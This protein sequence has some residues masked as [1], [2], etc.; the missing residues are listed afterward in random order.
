MQLKLVLKKL[1]L[2]ERRRKNREMRIKI[3]T[4]LIAIFLIFMILFSSCFNIIY[5]TEDIIAVSSEELTEENEEIETQE[6][7]LDISYVLS[8]DYSYIIVEISLETKVITKIELALEE[9]VIDLTEDSY[10]FDDD[11]GN[12]TISDDGS[13]A[14]KDYYQNTNDCIKITYEDEATEI[15]NIAVSGLSSNKVYT[16]VIEE[17]TNEDTEV[18]QV[19]EETEEDNVTTSSNDDSGVASVSEDDV[20]SIAV[21]N[22]TDYETITETTLLEQNDN[23]KLV[24]DMQNDPVI[25][26]VTGTDYQSYSNSYTNDNEYNGCIIYLTDSSWDATLDL[27]FDV[28]FTKVGTYNGEDIDMKIHISEITIVNENEAALVDW[29]VGTT[30]FMYWTNY[31]TTSNQKSDNEWWYALVE[32]FRTRIVFYYTDEA[33]ENIYNK[34]E[35]D[36]LFVS[37]YSLDGNEG[38]KSTNYTTQYLFDPT[39][40]KLASSYSVVHCG[41]TYTNFFYGSNTADSDG[42]RSY[43]A[44]AFLGCAYEFKDKSEL[45]F[46][47]GFYDSVGISSRTDSTRLPFLI[48]YTDS[49]SAR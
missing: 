18:A 42:N 14:T 37:L 26:N 36:D 2:K 34:I 29:Y 33:S 5:A 17:T 19:S 32:N 10:T 4:K 44:G 43:G 27:E 15:V 40:I 12:W 22:S 11:T 30:P 6:E 21:T 9:Y 3:Q 41:H 48:F 16:E 20:A 38:V 39:G 49:I 35:F 23:E 28:Y 7:T 25:L 31:G 46:Y 1:N 8:E 24:I 13:T 45:I 47:N